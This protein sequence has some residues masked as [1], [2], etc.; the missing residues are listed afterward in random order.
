[1]GT[2]SQKNIDLEQL[3]PEARKEIIDFYKLLLKKYEFKKSNNKIDDIDI[4]FKNY[5]IDLGSFK[6]DREKANER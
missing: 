5:N 3:P 6:F 2:N 4:F 1:M